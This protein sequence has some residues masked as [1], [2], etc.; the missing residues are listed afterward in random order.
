[1]KIDLSDNLADFAD[2]WPILN[3][4]GEYCSYAFQ[5]KDALEVWLD[6]IG[7]ARVTQP[8][9][10]KVSRPDGAPLM[11]LPLGIERRHGLKFLGF[12]DGGV[13]D[14]NAP[15]LFPGAEVIDAP[16]MRQLWSEILEKLPG[17]DVAMLEKIPAKVESR[18]NPFRFIATTQDRSDGHLIDLGNMA[19]DKQGRLKA[20]R[21]K[22]RS[23]KGRK[24]SDLAQTELKI[25]TTPEEMEHFYGILIR[26]KTRRYMETRGVDGFDRPGY[27]AYY[28]K[29][30]ERLGSQ[31]SVQMS[32]YVADGVH[33][34]SHWGITSRRRFYSLIPSYEAGQWAKFSPGMIHLEEMILWAIDQ[35]YETF[36]LGVGDEPYKLR[37]ENSILSL[38]R[39]E[40]AATALGRSYLI[41]LANRRMLAAGPVGD[42]VRGYRKWRIGKVA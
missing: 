1:M 6:T 17:F 8:L 21:Y 40:Q 26:Q 42:V 18:Q 28:W 39:S 23:G 35:G 37:I 7:A 27:R 33:I 13:S 25:A 41:F 34:A 22:Y 14:Y 12:L 16:A 19:K 31:G 4:P 5:A 38:S 10:V 9:F 32:A 20:L 15:V 11:L 2:V 3:Q 36:D 24:L 30:L 29:M